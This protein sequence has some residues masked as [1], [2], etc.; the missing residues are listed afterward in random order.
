MLSFIK[1]ALVTI[2]I[3]FISGVLL[4]YYRNYAPRILCS[5][6]RNKSI[7]KNSKKVKVYSLIIKNISK[8]TIHNLN[9][10]IAAKCNTL[11]LHNTK[12]T[13]G[14]RFDIDDENNMF[15]LSLIHI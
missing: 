6:G 5:M 4:D 7:R 11:K 9:V 3:S 1:T 13:N 10:N 12:I 2:I 8:K 15:N 14:L